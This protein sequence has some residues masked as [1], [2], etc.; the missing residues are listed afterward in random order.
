MKIEI[1]GPVPPPIQIALNVK[2]MVKGYGAI[3]EKNAKLYHCPANGCDNKDNISKHLKSYNEHKRRE[4]TFLTIRFA[5]LV[6]KTSSC[7]F[8]TL[9]V[10]ILVLILR[11]SVMFSAI[12]YHLYNLKNVK[13]T[14]GE[15]LLLVK[16]QGF[17][18]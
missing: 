12:W 14:Q 5:P 10:T 2:R 16:L 7:S 17:K 1:K 15:V 3:K 9:Q 6:Q 8:N 4:K 13:N 11:I 18:G